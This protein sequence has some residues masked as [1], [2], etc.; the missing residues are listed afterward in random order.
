M[1][2]KQTLTQAEL[3]RRLMDEIRKHPE[4]VQISDVGFTRPTRANWDAAWAL[5]GPS[6]APPIAHE[7]VR[8]FQQRFDL[9]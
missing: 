3:K 1:T 8:Q 2:K 9:A 7:I 6:S 5:N 4:C